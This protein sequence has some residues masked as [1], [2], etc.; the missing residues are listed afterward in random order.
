[1]A[2]ISKS[3]KTKI[4][5][6]EELRDSVTSARLSG[7]TIVHCHGCFDIVH[8]GHVR[9]L[10]FAAKRADVLLVTISGDD[11]INKGNGRPLIPQNLRAE[12]LAA[13]NCVDWVYID[14]H[15]TAEDIIDEVKPDIYLKGREYEN[16]NDVRF[17]AERE[18]VERYGG[19]VVFSS[20]DIIF[21]STELIAALA[22]ETDKLTRAFTQLEQAH[23]LNFT[24]LND[25]ITKFAHKNIVVIGEPVLDTYIQCEQPEIASEGPIM[26]LR[27]ISKQ[28]HDGGAAIICQHIKAMGG[29]V[30]L[31]TAIKS[32][33]TAASAMRERLQNKGINIHSIESDQ[34]VIEKE[35]YIVGQQK[36]MKVDHGRPMTIDEYDREKFIQMAENTVMA[37]NGDIDAVIFCDFGQGLLT[38]ATLK[39]LIRKLRNI[40]PVMTGDISGNR[41]N[42]LKLS[43][44]DLVC[45]T[46]FELRSAMHDF[47]EGLNAVV[48]RWMEEA[49]L[50][51][52]II[53]M[54]VDGIIA[55]SKNN[56]VTEGLISDQEH[57][58]SRLISEHIPL[59]GPIGIDALGCG[60]ALLATA[61]L[62]LTAGADLVQS[63]YLGSLA[64]ALESRQLGNIAVSVNQL[65]KECQ[66]IANRHLTI[67]NV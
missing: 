20:G 64:A 16:N 49:R 17:L 61:T 51:S 37:H 56:K 7:K 40:T 31:I 24:T 4:L 38:P 54:D 23:D 43:D 25:I 60:D 22:A 2:V 44:M 21:S 39:R 34:P 47:S 13:L 48:W 63:A 62:A 8:P 45:P 27:P 9:H 53:T 32:K 46:E 41:T 15:P 29:A 1:M 52:S 57:K 33:D 6:L 14:P 58:S 35:R 66:R 67:T 5:S 28:T 55:F 50:R 36:V 30:D 42:L 65:L 26:T 3:S 12:N 11:L 59:M 18:A 10:E 19:R